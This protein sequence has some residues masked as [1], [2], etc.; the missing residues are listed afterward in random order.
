MKKKVNN[1]ECKS[2]GSG[3]KYLPEK[4]KLFCEKCGSLQDIVSV[5]I[6]EKNPYDKTEFTHVDKANNNLQNLSCPNCGAEVVMAPLEYSR[7]C[8]YCN[9]NLISSEIESEDLTP[10]GIMPFKFGK[11]VASKLYVDGIRKKWF[12]PNAFKK[13]PPVEGIHGI[14]VPTFSF[15]AGSYSQYKGV[16]AKDSSYTDSQGHRHTRT[17][18]QHISGTHQAK[19]VDVVVEASSKINQK[20]MEE[21]KPYEMSQLV[22]FDQGFI[23]GYTVEHYL[24]SLEECKKMSEQIMYQIIKN[25]ILSKYSYDR[26]SSF[27]MTT[28]Y[29]AEK[30][31]YYL[32]PIYKCDYKYKDKTYTTIMNGQT[33]KVSGGVPRSGV[34]ITFLVLGIVLGVILLMLLSTG[35]NLL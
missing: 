30:Y 25:Q 7:T 28:Q 29:I 21:I 3:L 10:D 35:F 26:V 2:C 18:Y 23:L 8:P 19:H 24:N 4:Q 27:D 31:G 13:A 16:L 5:P 12:L 15:D 33:G 1:Y 6:K 11:D 14:Y 20:Q 9:S 32:L 34:K 17:S 22:K